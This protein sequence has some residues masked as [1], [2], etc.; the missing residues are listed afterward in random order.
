MRSSP[1]AS[2]TTPSNMDSGS[3]SD[4]APEELTAVQG[5]EKHDEIS[6]VEKD[7]AIRVSQQE[8]ERRRRWAQRRT[9][10]KPDKKEP[11]EVEDKDI[12]QKAENEEDEESEET[13]TM[14]GMLPTNVIEMLA[15]RE[16]QTFSSD[17]EEEITNQ[18]VQKRKKRLKSSGYFFH[19]LQSH[20]N[21]VEMLLM[22]VLL[23]MFVRPETI[24]LKDVRSTQHVK[25]ALAFLEQRKNQVPRSNAV[26]KNANKALRLLSSK[27]N[28]L[29]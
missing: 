27:G 6:K 7:S 14:P 5:V 20:M 17:S 21:Y 26:L 22:L 11:L 24:L 2:G 29:S 8:K 16:K 19:V 25:N 3:E 15:A 9:S 23:P 12:K 10:S 28:F 18:K 1:A 13:H 4:S